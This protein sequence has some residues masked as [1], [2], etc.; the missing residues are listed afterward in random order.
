MV[1]AQFRCTTHNM[2]ITILINI[3]RDDIGIGRP[4]APLMPRAESINING[5][6]T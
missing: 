4:A 1:Q 3:F 6:E 2:K 5:P